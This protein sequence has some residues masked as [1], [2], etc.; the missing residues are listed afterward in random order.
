MLKCTVGFSLPSSENVVDLRED[1]A[2]GHRRREQGGLE[3]QWA[4]A[5]RKLL[6]KECDYN[7]YLDTDFVRK[8]GG[9]LVTLVSIVLWVSWTLVRLSS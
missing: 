2:M 7:S 5:S 1:W 6:G 4:R 8:M 9:N 3:A